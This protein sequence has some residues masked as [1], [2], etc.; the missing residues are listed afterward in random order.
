MTIHTLLARVKAGDRDAW[1][2][3][4]DLVQPH[5]LRL[6][7]R[8]LGPMW[9]QESVSDLVQM[10]WARALEHIDQCRTGADDSQSAPLFRAWLSQ[11]L[12][13]VHRNKQRDGGTK[14]RRPPGG[15]RQ[16]DPV[17]EGEPGVDVAVSD[18]TASR[19]ARLH[20][21][22]TALQETMKS[23]DELDRRI[24]HLHFFEDRSLRQI[25]RDLDLDENQIFTRFKRLKVRLQREL[26][27]FD[28]GT[29]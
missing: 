21:L 13:N 3:L 11:V 17:A 16:L 2:P 5:L 15:L 8:R 28:D 26:G 6:A 10:T 4:Y 24:I 19:A 1:G 7:Q 23:L 22:R 18:P 27:E 12:R 25:A 14:R 9:P 20:E 29:P